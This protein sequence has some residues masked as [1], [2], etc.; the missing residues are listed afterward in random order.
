MRCFRR[1]LRHDQAIRLTYPDE[2]LPGHALAR[3]AVDIRSQYRRDAA[4]ADG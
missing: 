1:S 3:K 4:S 2:S